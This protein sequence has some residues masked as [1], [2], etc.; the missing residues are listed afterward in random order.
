VLVEMGTGRDD[1]SAFDDEERRR[2]RLRKHPG[3]RPGRL[4]TAGYA[5]A[6]DYVALFPAGTASLV[7]EDLKTLLLGVD[8]LESDDSALS[9]ST[10]V[11]VDSC[12]AV[13]T[14]KNLFL[15]RGRVARRDLNGAVADLA[16]RVRE[17]PR[18][19]GCSGF[20]V[21]FHVDGRLVP[22]SARARQTLE[23]AISAATGLRAQARGNCQEYWVIGR[24][25]WPAMYLAERLPGGKQRH[26]PDKGSLSGEL[27]ALLV[28]LSR[29]DPEDVFL[30]PFAGSGSIV[31]AR[32][33]TPARKV[34]Y[35]DR[36]KSLRRSAAAR[37]GHHA[38]LDFRH[39]DG[40]SMAS[41]QPAEVT[42]I[43]TDPPWGEHDESIG[44][45]AT[46]TRCVVAEFSRVLNPRRG[47]LVLLV[48]R[49]R[50]GQLLESLVASRFACEPP[51]GILVS[52]H[53]AS[54]IRGYPARRS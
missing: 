38:E 1:L 33:A 49:R 36:D 16:N 21:M 6:V 11:R 15:V 10:Q 18:P 52:G 9:F 4:L 27:S 42:A 43:V 8:V 46:F 13:P 39:E 50:A 19:G 44:D 26:S 12:D 29:P 31:A 35:N 2:C 14:A 41:V 37:L 28:S 47:R 22:S 23:E 54:V 17:L 30:D 20:R 32:L 7:A 25:D 53:P 24:R 45:Y 51:V 3:G 34:I 5:G 40:T 48:S